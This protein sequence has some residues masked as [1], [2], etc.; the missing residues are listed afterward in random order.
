MQKAKSIIGYTWALITVPFVLALMMS[1]QSIYDNIFEKNGLKVT[2]RISGGKVIKI[3]PREDYSIHQ[4]RPVFDGLFSERKSGFVQIDFITET[5]L[6]ASITED[7]DY[8]LDGITDFE[9]S[10]DT[11][12]NNYRL[13]PKTDSVGTLSPEGVYVLEKRRTIRVEIE[14]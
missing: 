13:I 6:P 7:I 1:S 3:L 14:K 10:I 4:H 2:D 9:F 11:D 5:G 12:S 8:N